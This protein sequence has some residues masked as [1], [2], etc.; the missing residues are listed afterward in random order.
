MCNPP[1]RSAAACFRSFM[2]ACSWAFA[3]ASSGAIATMTSKTFVVPAPYVHIFAWPSVSSSLPSP[4]VAP[5]SL[6][7]SSFGM[8]WHGSI[9]VGT[10]DG[11]SPNAACE[12]SADGLGATDAGTAGVV[13]ADW[14]T[15][16]GDAWTACD[17]S[18]DG[19]GNVAPAQAETVSA[20]KARSVTG[21][22]RR[23]D[24]VI[25]VTSFGLPAGP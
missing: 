5:A 8:S 19:E 2:A 22:R 11:P 13:S 21:V 15:T 12:P 20:V 6:P 16:G 25:V 23:A 3:V 9:D 4:N 14:S 17:A 18:A 7:A 24:R 10:A 1:G